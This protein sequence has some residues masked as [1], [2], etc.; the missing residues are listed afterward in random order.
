MQKMKDLIHMR[1]KSIAKIIKISMIVTLYV[2]LVLFVISAVFAVRAFI[3]PDDWSMLG[4]AKETLICGLRCF[5]AGLLP[6]IIGDHLI[7]YK[8]Y[9]DK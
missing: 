6:C 3:N 9:E 1:Y 8:G 2:M 4:L 7:R 5:F